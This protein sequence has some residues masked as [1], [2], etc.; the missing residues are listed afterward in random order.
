MTKSVSNIFTALLE[1]EIRFSLPSSRIFFN[2]LDSLIRE[3][4]SSTVF[5]ILEIISLESVLDN[6]SGVDFFS[7]T[8]DSDSPSSSRSRNSSSSIA[9]GV[10]YHP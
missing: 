9:L 5:E 4:L 3:N 6:F 7:G 2:S 1:K 8:D 10:V